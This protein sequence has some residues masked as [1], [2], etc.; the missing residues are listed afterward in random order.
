MGGEEPAERTLIEGEQEGT[1]LRPCF[2]PQALAGLQPHAPF[3]WG[4]WSKQASAALPR[5]H[6]LTDV[7]PEDGL[8]LGASE[9][10]LE[11]GLRLPVVQDLKCRSSIPDLREV[12]HCVPHCDGSE[13]ARA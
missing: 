4:H 10:P 12:R 11:P 5:C 3:S 13:W 7:I 6:Y 1:R 9:L 8:V 2:R